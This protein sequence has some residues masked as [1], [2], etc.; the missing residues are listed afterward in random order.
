MSVP[1]E[2]EFA[3]MLVPNWASAKAAAM[4]KTPNLSPWVALSRNMPS[5][6]RGFQIGSPPKMT[7][8]E[9]DTM[10]PMNDV[11]A[12]PMGIVNNCDQ[13]ASFGFRA[14]RAKSGS[15]TIKV[16]KLAILDMMPETI[17]QPRASPCA[18]PP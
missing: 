14:K 13:K 16:A 1:A 18:F 15:F 3:A 4:I 11:T 7:A 6:S 8:D 9:E 2:T 17:A 5:K 10:M 12:K